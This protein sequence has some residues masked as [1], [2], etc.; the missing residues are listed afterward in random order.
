MDSTVFPRAASAALIA[1]S[2]SLAGCTSLLP[3]STTE[4]RTPWSTYAEAEAMYSKVVT[5][6]TTVGEL[7]SLGVDPARTP[8]VALLSNA[9]VLRRVAAN[10]AVDVRM[11]DDRLQACLTK[12]VDCVGYEV[13][14][15]TTNKKRVGN[16]FADFLTFD[17]QTNVSGWQF[18]AI[19]VVQDGLVIYKLWSGKPQ[20]AEFERQVRPLGPL[21]NLGA[22]LH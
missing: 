15:T 20:I 14:Q 11:F 19:F 16:F 1:A 9:D 7:Q 22:R 5:N 10:G 18:K 4:T 13:E 12:R 6:K 8:N 17:Q 21:Q 2:L 3:N